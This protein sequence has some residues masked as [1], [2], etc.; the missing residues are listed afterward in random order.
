[1]SFVKTSKDE[2]VQEAGEAALE[3]AV[4][5][6]TAKVSGKGRE[7]IRGATSSIAEDLPFFEE[8]AITSNIAKQAVSAFVGGAAAV[9]GKLVGTNNCEIELA[10]KDHLDVR[11]FEVRERISSLFQITITALSKNP[12]IDFDEVVGQPARFALATGAFTREWTGLC[13]HIELVRVA[14]DGMSTYQISVVPTLWLL[15]Q[16]RNYRMF[17]QVSEPEIVLQILA[18]WNIAPKK[19]YDA[20]AYKKRKYRVQYAESDFTFISRM[21]EDAGIA[22]YFE[23]TDEGTKLVLSDAAHTNP[24]REG[25]LTFADDTSSVRD[26]GIKFVTA[27]RMSQQVK[28]GKVTLRDHD[29]RRPPSYKLLASASGGSDIEEKLERYHYVPGAFLF[30]TDQGEST[31]VADD[32]GKARTD[33]KEAAVLAQKCLDAHRGSARVC[34]FETNAHDLAPGVVMSF[35]GHPHAA[36]GDGKPLLVIESSLRGT[37]QGEWTHRCAARGTDVPFRPDQETPR[38]TVNGVESATVVGP[39]GEEIH[40]DEFGRVRVHFHWDRE[41][42]MDEKSSCW[43]HVSQ[44]WGGAGYGG[45]SLPRIGQEVL[46]DFLGGDP[47][48]PVI[49]GRVYTGL[50]KTPY[51]LPENKTQSGWKS[52][53][54]GGGGGY[55]ELMFEDAAGKELLRMQAEKDLNKLV[56]ND[57]S[58]NIGND[59]TKSIGHDDTLTVG[60]DRSRQVGNNESVT[61]GVNQSVTIGSNHTTT[62]GGDQKNTVTGS[63][64]NTVLGQPKQGGFNGSHTDITGHYKMTASDTSFMSAP[65]KITLECQ[66]SSITLEP[67]KI[68]IKA[69]DNAHIV[70]DANAL[71]KSSSGTE[72]FLDANAKVHSSGNSEMFLDTNAKMHSSGNSQ[73]FLDAN[74]LLQASGGGQTLCD[75]NVSS[76]GKVATVASTDGAGAQFTADATMSGTNVNISGGA[77]VSIA[78]PAINS[79]AAGTN[80]I[81]GGVVKIN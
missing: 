28:P 8:K 12:S 34:T 66:G 50:Q 11:Q 16:R 73:V 67:G 24:A 2:A 40:T 74:A 7:L 68:T 31:P 29:Y 26:V 18:E 58:V 65:N 17:Q 62:V 1:M 81:T 79:S 5:A 80:E 44:P 23:Q 60:N 75:A 13:N 54:T 25:A 14:P 51:K 46:V 61:I 38:P 33:E 35:E 32:K 52:N 64:F 42:K 78:A 15:T 39:S 53:S 36:I 9:A 4:G 72:V 30:G 77:K 57:E 55:N 3:G 56:K 10:S 45:S 19:Q 20:G 27:V 69:G 47:D 48:R 70:L 59:R 43:I 71:M 22:Y 21:L 49:V 37:D 63:Q 76:T 41:S 6:A